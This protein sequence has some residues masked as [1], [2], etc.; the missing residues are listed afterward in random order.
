M[1]VAVAADAENGVI[2][3]QPR[4]RKWDIKLIAGVG[5]LGFALIG[6]LLAGLVFDTT[7]ARALSA[8]PELPPMWIAGG[9]PDH[10]LGTESLGRDLWALT[11]A[12]V[13]TSLWV[14]AFA[15]SISMV[16][17]IVLGFTAGLK[18]G[19]ADDII[20]S[21]SDAAITIPTFGVLIVF[22]AY[23]TNLSFTT[24]A[25]LLSVFGWAWPTR[26]I[27]AQVLTIRERGYVK[28]ARLEGRSTPAIM[29][30]EMMPNLLPY[31]AAA[32][33]G[34]VSG[35]IL[36]ATSLEA[37]GLGPT[38][39]P[40]LGSTLNS[41]L[42]GSAMLRGMWW[43]WGPPVFVLVWIFVSLFLI[44]A[45]LD[46]FVNPRLQKASS[47]P[48]RAN[49]PEPLVADDEAGEPVAPASAGEQ[50]LSIR[51]LHVHYELQNRIVQAV[52]GVD[53]I[54]LRGEAVGLIGESGCG[55]S[56]LAM[57][58]LNLVPPPGVI[59]D[60][61]VIINGI[62]LTELD[63]PSLR[64][65][66]WAQVSLI[67]QGAMN[68][69]NPVMR[70]RDQLSEVILAHEQLSSEQVKERVDELLA[71]VGLPHRVVPMYPHELSG[72][73]KQRVS[74]AMAVA[75]G[76]D[77]LVADEA[78]SALDVV[79]QRLVIQTLLDV[80]KHLGSSLVVAGHD[81]ALLAQFVDRL[82]VMKDG[83]IVELGDAASV[84]LHP[85][86]PYTQLLIA[87]VP[88]FG[89]DGGSRSG[90][91]ATIMAGGNLEP[92]LS[93][94]TMSERRYA[95]LPLREVTPGHFAAVG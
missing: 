56:T 44:V 63:E 79:T 92:V 41:A 16:I 72:G 52:N 46:E 37:L 29:F 66:R 81:I 87:S 53:L 62:D 36:S 25:I 40:S 74:I 18:G 17:A 38:R 60:G 33:F 42:Q 30:G 75:L 7:A 3:P 12:G 54:V 51:N 9:S 15:A 48:G 24:M 49:R 27:R 1:T 69:L 88:A 21:V 95:S 11:I 76:P 8:P 19:A 90:D 5:M 67:P 91:F 50:V 14:G 13:P 57:G 70:V 85:V 31:L 59:V 80:K 43:W 82:A 2:V 93:A 47:R 55:K 28:L 58:I 20:R 68:S 39:I 84:L 86:H 73:M 22:A 26:T 4:R 94:A 35:A 45:G 23:M 78:T 61:T 6:A 77:L 83:V 34:A 64:Q 32:F 65:V 89:E 10:P 71:L